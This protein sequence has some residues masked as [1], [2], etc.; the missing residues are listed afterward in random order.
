MW[1]RHFRCGRCPPMLVCADARCRVPLCVF[2]IVLYSGSV[3]VYSCLKWFTQ[4]GRARRLV[5]ASLDK[6]CRYASNTRMRMI[7]LVNEEY[8]DCCMWI[9]VGTQ[10]CSCCFPSNSD[11]LPHLLQGGTFLTWMRHV[12]YR[13]ETRSVSRTGTA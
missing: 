2:C 7:G 11:E 1:H 8:V 5:P 13:Q 9:K 4:V 6:V 12:I 10:S 3:L